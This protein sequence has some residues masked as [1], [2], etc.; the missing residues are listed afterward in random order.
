MVEGCLDDVLFIAKVTVQDKKIL[1][2]FSRFSTPGFHC[3]DFQ[4]LVFADIRYTQNF[5]TKRRAAKFVKSTLNLRFS[6]N[7]LRHQH[8]SESKQRLI[9]V[10]M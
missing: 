6:K 10:A 8:C 9:G 7:Y 3:I 1:S 4:K 2:K 5:N